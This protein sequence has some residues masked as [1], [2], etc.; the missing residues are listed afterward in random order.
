MPLVSASSSYTPAGSAA[1]ASIDAARNEAFGLLR[2]RTGSNATDQYLLRELRGRASGGGPYDQRTQ[3]ALFTQAAEDAAAAE[4]AQLRGM[5]GS[6][7]DPSNQ[8][9]MAEAAARR[10]ATVQGAHLNIAQNA[11]VAN[12]NAQGQNLGQLAGVNQAQQQVQGNAVQN[13]VDLLA[14]EQRAEQMPGVPSYQQYAGGNSG[15][16]L[17]AREARNNQWTQRVAGGSAG[18][19]GSTVPGAAGQATRLVSPVQAY[20]PQQPQQPGV[21]RTQQRY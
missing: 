9:A 3:N 11:N 1:P 8:A 4:R 2:G 18:G 10:Q 16:T 17:A 7:T 5:G 12:Y 6:A 19:W 21:I 15:D 20:Q 14:R 13:L